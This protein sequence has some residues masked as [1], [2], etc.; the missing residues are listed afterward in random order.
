MTRWIVGGLVVLNLLLGGAVWMRLGGEQ[1]AQAQF[2]R[3]QA[4]ISVVSGFSGG[5]AIV[6]VLEANT[7][8]LLAVKTDP[9]NRRVDLL[10]RRNVGQ[11]MR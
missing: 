9:V 2:G 11:D 6:Y 8:Q 7:G 1:K 10:T 3:G 5:Q 4:N